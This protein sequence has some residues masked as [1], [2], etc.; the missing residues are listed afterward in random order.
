MGILD[1]VKKEMT[2]ALDH[3]KE[4]LKNIRTGRANPAI[5]DSVSVD[6]YGSQMRI[7]ELGTVSAPEPR[8]L[9]ITPFDPALKGAISKAIEKANLGFM[10]MVDGNQVRIKIPQM[11]ENTRKEMAKLCHKRREESKVSIRNVRRDGNEVA[12]KQKV[13]GIIGE[14]EL[15]KIEKQIQELTDKSCKEADELAEKKEKEV[16]AI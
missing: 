8:Q 4:E 9:L 13:D 10:P 6:A 14:D 11:D 16:M 3:L 2:A 1:N 12:R 5:F 7:K 15:K